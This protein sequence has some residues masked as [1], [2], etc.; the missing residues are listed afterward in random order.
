M[1][2]SMGNR[3]DRGIIC[4]PRSG[5]PPELTE[6][7]IEIIGEFIKEHPNSP[8]IIPAES[9]EKTCKKF[10][11]SSLKR[12]IK[13]LNM[14]RKR[15]R[16]TVRKKRDP[17]KYEKSLKEIEKMKEQQKAGISDSY[18][19]DRTGFSPGSSVPYAYQPIG[20]TIGIPSSGGGRLNV[21]GFYSTDNITE[22][23]CFKNTI[24]AGVVSACFDEFSKMLI[25]KLMYLSI[26]LRCIT[27]RN[28]G[29]IFRDGGKESYISDIYRPI[30]PN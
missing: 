16:K 6:P 12:V 17:E 11:M 23:F 15:V 9:I 27:V 13:K 1:A 21:I 14:R 28:S 30:R 4:L 20:E 8:K 26:I 22:S 2:E 7:D 3:R 24:H 25:K 10:S 19:S 29:R 18:F 5:A